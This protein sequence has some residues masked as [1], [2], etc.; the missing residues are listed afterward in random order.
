MCIFSYL[1]FSGCTHEGRQRNQC[2]NWKFCELGQL[3]SE[4]Q[5]NTP[6]ARLKELFGFAAPVQDEDLRVPAGKR[7][8]VV[9]DICPD[10]KRLRDG[11]DNVQGEIFYFC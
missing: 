6:L 3:Q 8:K 10:C 7:L 11:D 1:K 9:S 5:Q 4:K 2:D